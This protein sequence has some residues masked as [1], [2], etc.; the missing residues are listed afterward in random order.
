[1]KN[2]NENAILMH[3]PD[4]PTTVMKFITYFIIKQ[5]VCFFIQFMLCF[6]WSTKESL[7]PFFIK[8]MINSLYEQN[9]KVIILWD[10]LW[11]GGG[12]FFLWCVMEFAMR[13]QGRLAAHSFSQFRA[14]IRIYLLHHINKKSYNYFNTYTT[15]HISSTFSDIPKACENV[16]EIFLL[17]VTSI[18]GAVI[19]SITLLSLTDVIF[20]IISIVWLTLHLWT[21][22]YWAPKC[23]HASEKH[24]M[25]VA[26]LNGNIVDIFMNTINVFLFSQ[27]NNELKRLSL[28]Q[29]EEV[30]C[31]KNARQA[32]ENLKLFQSLFA[33]FYLF[34]LLGYLIAGWFYDVISPGDFALVPIIAFSLLGMMWWFSSQIPIIFRNIGCIKAGLRLFLDTAEGRKNH[35]ETTLILRQGEIIFNNISFEY[36]NGNT[37]FKHLSL[38]IPPKQTI[39]L[40]GSSGSGKSTLIQLLLRLYDVSEGS[41]MIDNQNIYNVSCRSLYQE[42]AVIPQEATLFNRSIY[43]NIKYGNTT[44]TD[45]DIYSAARTA[46]CHEFIQHLPQGYHSL[47]G[48][49]GMMLSGGQRQRICIAR[50]VIKNSHILIL[51]EATSALDSVTESV[52]QHNLEQLTQNR[53]VIIITHNINTLKMVDRV[54]EFDHGKIIYDGNKHSILQRKTHIKVK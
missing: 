16:L 31:S 14:D 49:K 40:I 26:N 10:L 5:R 37:V 27:K 22:F 38:C 9:T 32:I 45:E 39:G 20:S 7:F 52:I 25:A 21:N 44:A 3:D 28:Y 51:D 1:M 50:A 17:H 24:A 54:I 2:K 19:I 6:G 23:H 30:R 8:N 4:T 42:I 15:G 13:L 29:K 43:D 53:T 33:G 35:K 11:Q 46:G 47:A 12:F 34:I 36:P 48:E 41:I 18:G